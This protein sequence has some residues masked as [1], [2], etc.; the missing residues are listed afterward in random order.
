MSFLS[1]D[2]LRHLRSITDLPDLPPERYELLD[3][4]GEGGMGAVYRAKDLVLD[5]EVAVKVL[6]LPRLADAERERMLIEARVLAQLEHPG[7]VPVHDAGV[8][9]DGRVFYTMKLVRGPRL[10]A[11]VAIPA[12]ASLPERVRLF[13]RIC[14][15]VAFAHAHGVIHRDLKPANVMVGAFGEVLVLD[16]GAAKV[17]SDVLSAREGAPVTADSQGLI[18]G[19]P[20]FMAPEQER[21]DADAIDE[22]TDV[23][24]LGAILHFLFDEEPPRRLVA[25]S[26]KANAPD[27]GDRYANVSALI[28]DLE[29][30]QE[31]RA[32]SAYRDSVWERCERFAARYR[33]FI[34]LILAYLAMRVALLLYQRRG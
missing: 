27:P 26:K 31:G 4:V 22:R 6:S 16:W 19:T 17:R 23:F 33:V 9:S 32:I 11:Y 24:A 34:L 7:I 1:D 10:D 13:A 25:I 18:L 2:A 20:G 21:G 12:P 29:R 3:K 15:A 8:L 14:E 5:R 28:A 30:Y